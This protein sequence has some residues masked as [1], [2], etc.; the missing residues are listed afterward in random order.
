M[1]FP[2]TPFSK[3]S[4]IAA[5]TKARL[6]DALCK[7]VHSLG[8]I[9]TD[10]ASSTT[11]KPNNGPQVVSEEFRSAFSFHVY[12]LFSVMFFTESEAKGAVGIKD[13]KNDNK[14]EHM[15][16]NAVRSAC[17]KAMLS[18][19]IAMCKHKSHLWQRGVADEAV[20]MLPCRIAYQMLEA[21]TGVV[22]RKAACGDIALE[23][24]SITIDSS[25]NLLSQIVAALVDLLH[26][27][28]HLA[29]LVAELCTSI[30]KDPT[31]R[32]GVELLREI[33]RLNTNVESDAGGKASGIRNVAPFISELARL[34]PRLVLTSLS[35][36]LSHL[37]S[38]PYSIRSAI[39]TAIGHILIYIGISDSTTPNEPNDESESNL[40]M[41]KSRNAL[42]DI[43]IERTLD[44]SS[45]TRAAVLKAWISI[46]QS[47]ALPIDRLLV[48]TNL[49]AD[50]LQDKTVMVRRH[51]MQVSNFV[52]L[53]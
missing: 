21:S 51:A 45:F 5:Q 10:F 15:E 4:S 42:L 29:P 43:L 22:A 36:I 31:N 2:Q 48:V 34:R 9:L 11:T 3:S 35:H 40:D 14:S 1:A 49:A 6:I 44:V 41:S 39:V 13:R 19:C 26:A 20:A 38:E 23:I 33:G 28:E 30:N 37:K 8:R 25:A 50:R 24:I 52:V 32:L 46:V 53:I 7:A 12:M 18:A 17:A 27:Y 16:L 47:G